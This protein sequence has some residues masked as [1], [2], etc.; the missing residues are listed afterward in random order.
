MKEF[1]ITVPEMALIVGTRAALGV[2]AGLLLSNRLSPQ[3]RK[4]AGWTLLLVGLI[5]TIPLA[6][7]VFGQPHSFGFK[8]SGSGSRDEG[9]N[10]F[11][12]A[13]PRREEM[14]LR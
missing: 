4:A 14:A 2:G 1:R 6:L 3:E 9:R 13:E 12:S 7:E 5:T 8:L 11:E 10:E